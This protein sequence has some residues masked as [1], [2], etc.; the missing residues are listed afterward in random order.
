LHREQAAA[1]V[2]VM[3]TAV[4]GSLFLHHLHTL[5]LPVPLILFLFLPRKVVSYCLHLSLQY[6]CLQEPL[7][8]EVFSIEIKGTRLREKKS[9]L[10]LVPLKKAYLAS[11]E[12]VLPSSVLSYI[13]KRH[14]IH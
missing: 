11:N 7:K 10:N 14:N 4:V 5:P 2:A 8:R 13:Q 12:G 6:Y 3:K 9:F 1:S